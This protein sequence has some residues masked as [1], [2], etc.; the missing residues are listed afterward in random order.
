MYVDVGMGIEE[1]GHLGGLVRGEVVH[2]D[3]DLLPTGLMGH[4]L[5]EEGH[6]LLGGVPTAVLPSTSPVAELNA[7]YRDSVAGRRYLEP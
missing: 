6:E 4:E 1:V 7:A 2:D 3:L 5:A